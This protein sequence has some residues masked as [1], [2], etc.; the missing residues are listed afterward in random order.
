[1]RRRRYPPA[2]QLAAY[3]RA[4]RAIDRHATHAAAK[5]GAYFIIGSCGWLVALYL[6]WR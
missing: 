5:A 4:L 6:A 2:K 1:M 3:A